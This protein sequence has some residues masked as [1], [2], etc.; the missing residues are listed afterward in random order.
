MRIVML[1]TGPFAVPTFEWLLETHDVPALVTR[2]TPP[3]KGREK[4][5]LNPM[6]DIALARGLPILEPASI[7]T[8]DAIAA[9]AELRPE[10]LMV[11]D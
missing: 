4:A 6:R 11:C 5:P 2:P 7:N 10:L 3:A 9:V 1:G 8:P